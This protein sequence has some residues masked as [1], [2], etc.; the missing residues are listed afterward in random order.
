VYIPLEMYTVDS[1]G[2]ANLILKWETASRRN[3]RKK[4]RR[5]C[6]I[7]ELERKKKSGGKSGLVVG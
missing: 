7:L 5:A 2:N 4:S 6:P 3:E 1:H